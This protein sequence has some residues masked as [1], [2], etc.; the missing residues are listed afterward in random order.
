MYISIH[1]VFQLDVGLL[2]SV[3]FNG[4]KEDSGPCELPYIIAG[5]VFYWIKTNCFFYFV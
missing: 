3:H 4:K 1:V 5:G 2:L